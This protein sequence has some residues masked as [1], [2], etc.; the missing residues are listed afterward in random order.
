MND[1]PGGEQQIKL[2]A[3]LAFLVLFKPSCPCLEKPIGLE[4]VAHPISG[5]ANGG[6]S[7]KNGGYKQSSSKFENVENFSI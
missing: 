5:S 3:P 1:M 7:L 6:K 4:R 2:A